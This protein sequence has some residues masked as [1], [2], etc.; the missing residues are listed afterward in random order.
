MDKHSTALIALKTRD[1]SYNMMKMI[2]QEREVTFK[3]NVSMK[4]SKVPSELK[5]QEI[6]NEIKLLDERFKKYMTDYLDAMS[7][8]EKYNDEFNH[9]TEWREWMRV[10]GCGNFNEDVSDEDVLSDLDN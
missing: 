9:S 7:Y 10:R 1:D 3:K 4:L 5:I 8:L 6:R 2:S